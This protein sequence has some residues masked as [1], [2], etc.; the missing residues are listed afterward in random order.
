MILIVLLVFVT[1]ITHRQSP[2]YLADEEELGIA[3][4]ARVREEEIR[5]VEETPKKES[6]TLMASEELEQIR[7][8]P[9]RDLI[10]TE[11]GEEDLFDPI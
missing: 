7:D 8:Y 3:P 9:E 11:E 1:F 5:E 2:D 10:D 6:V 4:K